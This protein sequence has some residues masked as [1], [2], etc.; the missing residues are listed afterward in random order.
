MSLK[1]LQN[2][3]PCIFNNKFKKQ[4]ALFSQKNIYF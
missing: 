1:E 3:G 2:L 4:K